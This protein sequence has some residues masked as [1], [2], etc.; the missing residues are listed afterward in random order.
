MYTL[1]SSQV[2]KEC[3]VLILLGNMSICNRPIDIVRSHF[4]LVT[5]PG[6]RY[7]ALHHLLRGVVTGQAGQVRDDGIS[8]YVSVHYQ[9]SRL[10]MHTVY[11]SVVC[12]VGAGE[13][14]LQDCQGPF[15]RY[16]YTTQKTDEKGTRII[17]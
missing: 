4:V 7:A 6:W 1:Y 13:F 12:T 3:R 16:F 9:L 8:R 11:L 2:S 17:K 15:F 14:G 10:S 5:G